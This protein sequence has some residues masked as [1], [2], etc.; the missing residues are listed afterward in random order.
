[1]V[2]VGGAVVGVGGGA[3]DEV[4]GATVVDVVVEVDVLEVDVDVE[5]VGPLVEVV[6]SSVVDVVAAAA[7]VKPPAGTSRSASK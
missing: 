1:M 7:Q 3:V 2:V 6:L 5:V 4:V